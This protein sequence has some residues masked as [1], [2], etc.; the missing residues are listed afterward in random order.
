MSQ[1]PAI[2]DF[3]SPHHPLLSLHHLSS[4]TFLLCPSLVPPEPPTSTISF[5]TDTTGN[6]TL[7]GERAKKKREKKIQTDRKNLKREMNQGTRRSLHLLWPSSNILKLSHRSAESSMYNGGGNKGVGFGT[8][9][10][11]LGL[12]I[13]SRRKNT[14]RAIIHYIYVQ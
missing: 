7:S 10:C 3:L 2:H 1:S 5:M 12:K 13:Y 8:G 9:L 6:W 11:P 14:N 4:H